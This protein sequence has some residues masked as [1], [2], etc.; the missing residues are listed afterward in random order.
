MSVE[1]V[2]VQDAE[3]VAEEAPAKKVSNVERLSLKNRLSISTNAAKWVTLLPNISVEYDVKPEIW[4]R[5]SA[6]LS[7]MWNPA[8]KHTYHNGL[9]YNMF[10]IRGEFRNYWRTRRSSRRERDEHGKL[11]VD[12]ST[13]LYRTSTNIT[14]HKWW[15]DKL[16]SQRKENPKQM[17]E[18][19]RGHKWTH[20]R[21]LY[22]LFSDYSL[23]FGS[24]G[25]QG[26]ALSIGGTYGLVRQLYKY[27]NESSIDL[28][29]GVSVG[30]VATK[31]NRF[32][33]DRES[34]CFPVIDEQSL[35]F[36]PFPL[37][38]DLRVSLI[39]RL[40]DKS[41]H[42]KYR[43]R[44]DVDE[45]YRDAFDQMITDRENR[46]RA[47][48]VTRDSLSMMKSLD[49]VLVDADARLARYAADT[50][51]A[52]YILLNYE[53]KRVRS[54]AK[55]LLPNDKASEVARDVLMAELR[56][57]MKRAAFYAGENENGQS[58]AEIQAAEEAKKAKAKPRRKSKQP[59]EEVKEKEETADE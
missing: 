36:L 15:I 56:Y 30:F 9:V 37:P 34:N 53:L 22:A 42:D 11:M 41:S 17:D 19:Y 47:E 2:P 24:T 23:K 50:T 27:K 12:E 5:W 55:E 46:L 39:Y 4:N 14:E 10:E 49:E 57:Y 16:F 40:G 18:E 26:F 28:D 44:Y 54:E 8:N 38:T 32:A 29:L 51:S 33:Y 7:M 1:T 48:R 43:F 45:E 35:K 20:Y 31:Y 59:Q 58:V 6:V 3:P 25:Y 13:G 21:G 52:Q